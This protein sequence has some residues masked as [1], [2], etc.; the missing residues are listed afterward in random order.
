MAVCW[1]AYNMG[2]LVKQYS[3][4]D[5]GLWTTVS[6]GWIIKKAKRKYVVDA[7]S[8]IWK[9]DLEEKIKEIQKTFPDKW[10]DKDTHKLIDGEHENEWWEL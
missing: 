9:E 1:G 10:R 3:D 6:D 2:W 5:Y 4:G 8:Q 7:I